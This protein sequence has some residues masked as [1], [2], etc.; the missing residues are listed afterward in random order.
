[1]NPTHHRTRRRQRRS[2]TIVATAL[3]VLAATSACGTSSGGAATSKDGL[4]KLQVVLDWTPNTNHSGMY[5][6]RAKGWYRKAGLDV[7]FVEP[8]DS[9]S[10]QL[11]AAGKADVAV[12]V[13]EEVIPARA[14]GLPVQSVAA[15][16]PHNTSGLVSLASDG[17]RR[18]RDLEGKTYGGY[19][20][21][22]EKALVDRLVACDGGDPE[23]VKTVDVGEADYRVGLQRDT[24]D[25]VWIFDGWDG[26][27]LN[28][29]DKV[30]TNEL[31]FIDHTD[32]IPDWYT[33]LL[34]TSERMEASRPEDLKA[35]LAATARGYQTAMADPSAATV[36]LMAAAP[37]LDRD[38]VTRSARYLATR[39][40]DDPA[41]W[42]R[43][44]AEVW[45]SFAR[46]L[47]KADMVD[48]KVDVSDAWTNRYLPKG[49]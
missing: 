33:P 12:S 30:K 38:L 4:R 28:Q 37:D 21:Q 5:L 7:S 8:G 18:P 26:I 19:G 25:V 41:D 42:G 49:T 31:A 24:Y 32:C 44:R 14:Q 23:K 20:G 22:L 35:F 3:V 36:A 9:S 13:Q 10:L 43:Q 46:F 2:L 40:A 48:A 1:M 27:R 15:V 11:L 45:T 39:Y 29:I 6:A 17:I 47:A 34:A 16:M